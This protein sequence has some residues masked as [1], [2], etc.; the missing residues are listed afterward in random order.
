MTNIISDLYD[1]IHLIQG[2]VIPM[3]FMY[4]LHNKISALQC[5]Q[6]KVRKV[7]SAI[8][9]THTKYGEALYRFINANPAPDWKNL[10]SPLRKMYAT[11]SLEFY[12][13]GKDWC[14]NDIIAQYGEDALRE[15]YEWQRER[16]GER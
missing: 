3:E 14:D 13:A 6:P 7:V 11:S 8:L 1:N 9:L 12:K 5:E 10:E 2:D 4:N 16:E 15:E